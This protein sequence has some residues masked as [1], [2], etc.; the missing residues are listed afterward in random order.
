MK[1]DVATIDGGGETGLRHGSRVQSLN[2]RGTELF[3]GMRMSILDW[4]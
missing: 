1:G 2:R 3:Y 4:L